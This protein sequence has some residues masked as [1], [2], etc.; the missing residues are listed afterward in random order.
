MYHSCDSSTFPGKSYFLILCKNFLN[1]FKLVYEL[2]IEIVRTM[3][4]QIREQKIADYATIT[5]NR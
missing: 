3:F 1:R 4:T 2:F 5:M